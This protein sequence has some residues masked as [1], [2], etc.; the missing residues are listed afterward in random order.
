MFLMNF[1]TALPSFYT[2]YADV[3]GTKCVIH[4]SQNMN[5]AV[6]RFRMFDYGPS[7]NKDVYNAST[8]PEYDLTKFTVPSVIY[9][10]RGD[11]LCA[12]DVI[13]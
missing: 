1:Q 9:Y 8:P 13:I 11:N 3:I 2:N 5:D 6:P 7:K 4:Y 10:G 12:K